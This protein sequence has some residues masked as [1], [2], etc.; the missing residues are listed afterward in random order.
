MKNLAA[1]DA[2]ETSFFG[3][4]TKAD[5]VFDDKSLAKDPTYKSLADKIAIEN[6]INLEKEDDEN[7]YF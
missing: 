5:M 7:R 6:G 1:L 4:K 2:A 3:A